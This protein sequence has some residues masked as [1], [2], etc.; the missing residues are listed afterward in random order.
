MSEAGEM[1]P[2]PPDQEMPA[3]HMH[4]QEGGEEQDEMPSGSMEQD[5]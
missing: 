2:V 1:D 5:R 4:E 3:G